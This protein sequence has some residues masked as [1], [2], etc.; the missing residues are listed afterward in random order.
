[1]P[2]TGQSF[3]SCFSWNVSACCENV[4]ALPRPFRVGAGEVRERSGRRAQRLML[5]ATPLSSI[6]SM[7]SRRRSISTCDASRDSAFC[8]S[9]LSAGRSQADV[10]SAFLRAPR[11]DR[12]PAPSSAPSSSDLI[13]SAPSVAVSTI[14]CRAFL[15]FGEH[16]LHRHEILEPEDLAQRVVEFRRAFFE[17]RA[18]L[19]VGKEW[20]EGD[21]RVAPAE[22]LQ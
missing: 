5:R 3:P 19:V 8:V 18:Q 4:G 22:G 11:C 12:E 1:M 13:S 20:A 21:E 7:D 17:Q 10:F 15:A 2:Q 14:S 6:G 16:R 9:F